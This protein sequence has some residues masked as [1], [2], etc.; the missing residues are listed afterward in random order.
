MATRRS[1]I[2]LDHVTAINL[3]EVEFEGIPAVI[4]AWTA[5]LNHLNIGVPEGAPGE[6]HRTWNERRAELLAILLAKIAKHLGIAKGEIEIL[7]GGY[8][9]Q[10]WALREERLDALQEYILR[11]SHGQA[12][13]PVTTTQAV[14]PPNPYPPAPD[15]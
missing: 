12:V 14:V 13:L 7:H 10:G 2:S 5:Y 15:A 4:D 11:L 1:N 6:Q 3:V 8:A 9:P